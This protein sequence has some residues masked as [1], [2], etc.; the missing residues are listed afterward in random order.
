VC[1]CV[2]V[3][4]YYIYWLPAGRPRGRIRVP[5]WSRIFPS[6]RPDRLRG[7]P[8]LISNGYK[9]VL[10]SGVKRQGRE[11]DH[12]PSTSAEIKKCG[13]RYPSPH[14]PFWHI[15][16]LVKHSDNFY[17]FT[18]TILYIPYYIY[19][20]IYICVCVL[21]YYIYWLLKVVPVLN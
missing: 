14:T 18:F 20:N 4:S 2:C 8:S 3:L 19:I 9:G 17:L 12:S 5:V 15:Y 1:V 13:S 7:P 10:S 16:I 21:S 11:A 6:Q